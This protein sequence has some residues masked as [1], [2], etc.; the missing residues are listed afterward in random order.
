MQVIIRVRPLSNSEIAVQGPSRCVKQGSSQTVTWIG[1]P[2]ARFTFDHVADEHVTQ[3]NLFQ[4]FRLH[5][6][7]ASILNCGN[8]SGDAI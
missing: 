1:P 2:E 3:V 7:Y 5:H 6:F 4:L 8:I